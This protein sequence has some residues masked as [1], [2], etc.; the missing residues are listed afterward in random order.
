MSNILYREA[1]RVTDV[2]IFKS[3]EPHHEYIQGKFIFQVTDCSITNGNMVPIQRSLLAPVLFGIS[4]SQLS[5][6]DGLFQL[7]YYSVLESQ[8]GLFHSKT[9]SDLISKNLAEKITAKIMSRFSFATAISCPSI[10]IVVNVDRILIYEIYFDHQI[11]EFD[12]DAVS[13]SINNDEE[14]MDDEDDGDDDNDG[15]VDGNDD[16]DDDNN[17]N[18]GDVD[19]NDDS[20][21][22][23]YE[24]CFGD[25]NGFSEVTGLVEVN[26]HEVLN[27]TDHCCICLEE[28]GSDFSR[29]AKAA[30]SVCSHMF[31][32]ECIGP[33]LRKFSNCC[34]LCRSVFIAQ[35]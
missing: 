5:S 30:T 12:H 18:D 24:D 29:V 6:R 8:E 11:L 33:W 26:P 2:R 22:K 23:Y 4:P 7:I 1:A 3:H 31:H 32:K 13:S 17:D 20:D 14:D 16:N 25:R 28:Y 21:D 9:S 35:I 34:P 27:S 10:V 15:D 19:D